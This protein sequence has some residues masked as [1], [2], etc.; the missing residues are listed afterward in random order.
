[1]ELDKVEE[2][3][4]FANHT[5]EELSRWCKGL[6]YFHYLRARQGHNC[7]GDSFAAHFKYTDREDLLGK[8][9]QL[10]VSLNL[11]PKDALLFDPFG[12]YNIDN[13]DKIK[14]P[15]PGCDDL[16][17]PQDVVVFGHQVYMWMQKNIFEISIAGTD[18]NSA[19]HVS[20]KDF[21]VCL[22]LEKEFEKLGWEAFLD[23]GI[24]SLPHCISKEKY[25]ELYK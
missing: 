1:M 22:E 8:M 3:K 20:E 21:Q 10:G 17:Q 13:L 2:E 23:E 16:E 18:T 5:K 24:V 4:L 7:E 15:I 14:Y 12:S 9:S 11:L 19:Y 25:P 6:K